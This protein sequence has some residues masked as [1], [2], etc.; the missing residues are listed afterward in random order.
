MDGISILRKLTGHLNVVITNSGDAA[1]I[2][3]LRIVRK[4]SSRKVVLIPDQGVWLSYKDLSRL[5]GF[6]VVEIKTDRGLVDSG[7]LRSRISNAAALILPSFAGYYAEQPLK[8]IGKVCKEN[9]CVLV[10]DVSGSIGDGILCNGAISDVIF[11]GFDRWKL[12]NYG[13]YGF[14]SSNYNINLKSVEYE[15]ELDECIA[16]APNRLFELLKKSD[17]VKKDLIGYKI[18]HGNKRGLN[19]IA[20][21]NSKIINYCEER[22]YEYVV[23]PKQNKVNEK[24]I[25][26]ELKRL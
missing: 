4:L 19:V 1:L 17:H 20:E 24:A 5:A 18:F 6:D 10:E 23:C 15:R 2:E 14:V 3:A 21:Y 11:A 26:I 13:K 8:E 25:S 12:V 22:N 9:A 16:G 7:V